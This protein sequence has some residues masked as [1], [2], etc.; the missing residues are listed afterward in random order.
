MAHTRDRAWRRSQRARVIN[1]RKRY[2]LDSGQR[3][4]LEHRDE[5]RF[6][7]RHPMD[8]GGRCFMCHGDKLLDSQS[9]RA[10]QARAWQD[11][12]AEGEGIGC[13]DP[14]QPI[15]DWRHLRADDTFLGF[16]S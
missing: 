10:E 12:L 11:A 14:A 15:H 4:L 9:R 16:G 8:C 1:N 13:H 3:E 2:L 5:G 7:D 6:A